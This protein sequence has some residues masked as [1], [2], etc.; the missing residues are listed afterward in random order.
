MLVALVLTAGQHIL[1]NAITEEHSEKLSAV[2]SVYSVQLFLVKYRYISFFNYR[3]LEKIVECLGQANDTLKQKLQDY[4]TDFRAFCKHSVFEVPAV[5][6]AKSA[7]ACGPKK[8]LV[9]KINE[10]VWFG[11]S[12]I[13]KP[14]QYLDICTNQLLVY[15]QRISSYETS[16]KDVWKYCLYFFQMAFN[17]FFHSLLCKR[18]SFQTLGLLLL[19]NRKEKVRIKFL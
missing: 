16:K 6:I 12:A 9:I 7:P 3:I 17:H 19:S 2:K 11:V 8:H 14:S 1:P 5:V 4:L 15:L 18:R 13:K 10:K